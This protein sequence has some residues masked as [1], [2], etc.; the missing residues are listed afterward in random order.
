MSISEKQ[1]PSLLSVSGLHSGYGK[2][3]IL[4]GIDLQVNSGEFVGILGHNGMGKTTLLRTLMGHLKMTQGVVHFNGMDCTKLTPEKRARAGMGFV[5][6]GRQIFANLSV[7]ENLELATVNN[8]NATPDT[9]D[10][11][12]EDFP[13]LKPLLERRGGV[14][15]GGEQQLLALARCLATSPTLILLDE[16][17]EGIQPSIIEE[18]QEQLGKFKST[19]DVAFVLVEQNLEFIR[20]LS[21]RVMIMQKGQITKELTPQEILQP[22]LIHEFAGLAASSK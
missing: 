2:I 7:L 22:D 6:Q 8:P 11:L 3:P 18:I 1:Q 19:N 9:I 12:L 10:A 14:L 15:S 13:R 4:T 5:P 17:T 21:D 20:S 16:P